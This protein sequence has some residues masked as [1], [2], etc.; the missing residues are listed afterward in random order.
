M[1]N[2]D[3]ILHILRGISNDDPISLEEMD[4]KKAISKWEDIIK[5]IY[6]RLGITWTE[7]KGDGRIPVSGGYVNTPAHQA[8]GKNTYESVNRGYIKNFYPE[9]ILKLAMRG[10]ISFHLNAGFLPILEGIVELRRESSSLEDE[11]LKYLV[12]FLANATF[13]ALASNVTIVKCRDIDEVVKAGRKIGEEIFDCV[14]VVYYDT[15]EVIFSDT[16]EIRD[17]IG[18]IIQSHGLTWDI[19]FEKPMTAE[20]HDRK[21]YCLFDDGKLI[22]SR[23]LA[24]THK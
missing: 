21:R 19:E 10:D 8:T 20:I 18:E 1:T 14:G 15:D 9:L 23:G 4:F 12:K 5:Q 13:G 11:N 22:A 16:Q 3:T 6:T 17:H 24:R 7:E 2:K